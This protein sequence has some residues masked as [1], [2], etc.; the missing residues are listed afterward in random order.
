M[1]PT[2]EGALLP[3]ASVWCCGWH[4]NTLVLWQA[5]CSAEG[6]AHTSLRQRDTRR[7]FPA[8]CHESCA[9][10]TEEVL[11]GCRLLRLVQHFLPPLQAPRGSQPCTGLRA[12][13]SRDTT[14]R[15]HHLS[16]CLPLS[17]SRSSVSPSLS[18]FPAPPQGL[19]LAAAFPR[20]K[21][22]T[23]RAVGIDHRFQAPHWQ[24]HLGSPR[25]S[26]LWEP[27]AMG[28]SQHLAQAA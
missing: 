3:T 16:F 12:L 23:N 7:P 6:M 20:R 17:P 19:P 22:E 13:R 15:K 26:W 14:G 21:K 9:V 8:G 27:G 1:N 18:L 10:R 11:P 5:R 28:L 2:Q 4:C 25:H 24:H